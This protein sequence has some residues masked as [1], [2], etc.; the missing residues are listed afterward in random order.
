MKIFNF[1]MKME[2]H[3]ELQDLADRELESMSSLVRKFVQQGIDANK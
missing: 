3:T 1:H 2:Q